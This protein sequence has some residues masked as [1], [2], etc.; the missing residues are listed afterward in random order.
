MRSDV[1]SPWLTLCVEQSPP[2]SKSNLISLHFVLSLSLTVFSSAIGSWRESEGGKEGKRQEQ[3][4][5]VR[6]DK[7][8]KTFEMTNGKTCIQRIA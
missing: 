5:K 6:N 4:E 1:T 2:N 7:N 3:E 8:M